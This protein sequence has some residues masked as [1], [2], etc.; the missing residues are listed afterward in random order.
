L[1]FF[2]FFNRAIGSGEQC[3]LRKSLDG[4]QEIIFNK[5]VVFFWF[6]FLFFVKK[7]Y[8]PECVL[9]ESS[10]S[11]A[12]SDLA[13]LLGNP[14]ATEDGLVSMAVS[15]C[16]SS[17]SSGEDPDLISETR[18][19]LLELVRQ[20]STAPDSI[21]V[22]SC[23]ML[24]KKV[25]SPHVD[26]SLVPFMLQLASGMVMNNADLFCE[27]VSVV[28]EKPG[29]NPNLH[30][31]L[32][33]ILASLSSMALL[34][35]QR[36]VEL[37]RRS[38]K[39]LRTEIGA[40]CRSMPISFMKDLLALFTT[41][42]DPILL[43]T[44][45]DVFKNCLNG[46]VSERKFAVFQEASQCV[47]VATT[48]H[49]T[50]AQQCIYVF[51]HDEDLE[52]SGM[53][54]LFLIKQIQF[55]ERSRIFSLLAA[56][57]LASNWCAHL[58]LANI[59]TDLA[60]FSVWC[61]GFPLRA[62]WACSLVATLC[63]KHPHCANQIVPALVW[64]ICDEGSLIGLKICCVSVLAEL[65]GL[66][67]FLDLFSA[68]VT[69][70][71]ILADRMIQIVVPLAMESSLEFAF[72][73]LKTFQK[74]M[75]GSR[76]SGK[77]AAARGF[78]LLLCSPR[79]DDV[80]MP[81]FADWLLGT[82]LPLFVRR[83]FY[84]CLQE[85]L[86]P[87][88]DEVRSPISVSFLSSAVFTRVFADMLR[89]CVSLLTPDQKLFDLPVLSRRYDLDWL[90]LVT[91]TRII[92][93]LRFAC[94]AERL[95][96][97]EVVVNAV[98]GTL[99]V[100]MKKWKT[101]VGCSDAVRCGVLIMGMEVLLQI[102]GASNTSP[103]I[104]KLA[105]L[106]LT[107]P[108]HNEIFLSKVLQVALLE[109]VTRTKPNS[110]VLVPIFGSILHETKKITQVETCSIVCSCFRLLIH[111][112]GESASFPLTGT[113][114]MAKWVQFRTCVLEVLLK[115]LRDSGANRVSLERGEALF[116]HLN[117]AVLVVSMPDEMLTLCHSN[118][119]VFLA[120][121]LEFD[122]ASMETSPAL[123]LLEAYA[124][125]FGL[126]SSSSGVNERA[127]NFLV[128]ILG[129]F[130]ISNSAVVAALYKSAIQ[131]H[132]PEH[133]LAWLMSQFDLVQSNC[134][135]GLTFS[136]FPLTVNKGSA[137]RELS[138]VGFHSSM[139]PVVDVLLVYYRQLANAKSDLSKMLEHCSFVA[140]L[141]PPAPVDSVW[142]VLLE[143]TARLL[144][145]VFR[146]TKEMV[147]FESSEIELLARAASVMHQLRS[148]AVVLGIRTIPREFDLCLDK[149]YSFDCVKLERALKNHVPNWLSWSEREKEK[150]EKELSR[151]LVVEK[152]EPRYP[153]AMDDSENEEDHK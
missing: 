9:M 33:L 110:E 14:L 17:G 60:E 80:L 79:C 93:A 19:C 74:L 97:E 55:S 106:Y 142:P 83:Y 48:L 84:Q 153:E 115:C 22:T 32:H 8:S 62:T 125:L 59:A 56:S 64:R 67:S 120:A 104:L 126:L 66:T 101:I 43:L 42:E 143:T 139:E 25:S 87:S 95:S 58:F 81:S 39:S 113:E 128:Q 40:C 144:L 5:L 89:Q 138:V 123:I 72:S 15:L 12:F 147:V 85:T 49:A 146:K 116:C 61:F 94:G 63:N 11:N 70:N 82:G 45:C 111:L 41:T 65:Q 92:C 10:F 52:Q 91:A 23:L 34:L 18:T 16:L 31:V 114:A 130:R 69:S 150:K 7:K 149:I 102:G 151:V 76:L 137:R 51:E 112:C 13:L 119:L 46:P 121:K 132:D 105:G 47:L 73:L 103:F 77:F 3:C 30:E 78:A 44:V 20:H 6:F 88:R 54:V 117:E 71:N 129:E 21:W 27:F 140:G 134:D 98:S 109:L 127:A 24:A 50:L 108:V 145:L 4:C 68:V 152:M 86:I 131:L 57:K 1:T 124:A 90:T 136:R 118:F 133:L 100:M 148:N 107:L 135:A 53:V 96:G 26:V 141:D 75:C 122:L 99:S 38:M 35:P 2:F 29:Q 37:T 36:P 28:F